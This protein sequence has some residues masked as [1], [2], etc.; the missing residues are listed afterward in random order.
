MKKLVITAIAAATFAASVSTASADTYLGSYV[1]RIGENDHYASDGY[2][3]DTAAQMV[4]QDRANWHKFGVYDPEDEN[5]SWFGDYDTRAWLEKA[6]N[7]NS[8]MNK[9]TRKAIVNGDPIVQVDVY[10][11]SVKVTIIGY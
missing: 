11:N 8:A 5:D 7:R 3:L 4:R 6:L 10:Q 9:A 2:P 1:A